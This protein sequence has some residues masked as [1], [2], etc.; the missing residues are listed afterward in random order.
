MG[1]EPWP[2]CAESQLQG[3]AGHSQKNLSFHCKHCMGEVYKHASVS[4]KPVNVGLYA[5][6]LVA[7]H[8]SAQRIALFDKPDIIL[9]GNY[10]FC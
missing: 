6:Q 7:A 1:T 3:T 2:R 9:Q 5:R 4:T 8:T 10:M